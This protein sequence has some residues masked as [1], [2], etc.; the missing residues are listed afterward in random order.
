MR[1]PEIFERNTGISWIRKFL[2]LIHYRLFENMSTING[3]NKGRCEKMGI[4]CSYGI[5]IQ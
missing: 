5:S 3:I 4:D 2:L 1:T